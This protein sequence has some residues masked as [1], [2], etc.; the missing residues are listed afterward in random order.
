MIEPLYITLREIPHGDQRY[1]TVGDWFVLPNGSWHL[2]ASN[3][4]DWRYAFLVLVHELVE[5]A[6]CQHRGIPEAA[7]TQFDL[8]FEAQRAPGNT[9]EPGHDPLAPYHA[10]H[11]FAEGIERQLAEALGVQWDSY[12]R[13]IC[14]L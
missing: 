12:E 10:E 14:D 4:G 2:R 8:D 7:V 1:E 6:L 9:D 5:M 13:V 11:V 3:M